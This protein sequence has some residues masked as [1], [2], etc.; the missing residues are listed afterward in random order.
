MAPWCSGYHY[1][2]TSFR[3]PLD[4]RSEQD[5]ILLVACRRLEM[6]R[7]SDNGSGWK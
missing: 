6:V 5:Q 4:S 7:I 1:C 3:K 2:T